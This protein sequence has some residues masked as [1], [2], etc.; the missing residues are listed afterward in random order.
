MSII[1]ADSWPLKLP[2]LVDDFMWTSQATIQLVMAPWTA[3]GGQPSTQGT[4]INKA[5]LRLKKEVM[6]N[7]KNKNLK[8]YGR[9]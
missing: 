9:N 6:L 5:N 2:A 7:E 8:N 3:R 4:Q 1:A